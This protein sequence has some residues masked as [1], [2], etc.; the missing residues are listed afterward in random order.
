MRPPRPGL[1]RSA[2]S[3]E[4][5]V[6]RPRG[7]IRATCS[8][9]RVFTPRHWRV[10]SG[11]PTARWVPRTEGGEETHGRTELESGWQ[12]APTSDRPVDGTRPRSRQQSPHLGAGERHGGSDPGVNAVSLRRGCGEP[13]NSCRRGDSS[14]GSA[15]GDGAGSADGTLSRGPH[16]RLATQKRSEPQD[17]QQAATVPAATGR[18]KPSRW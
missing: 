14:R 4:D 8:R 6:T 12:Q 2:G 11:F 15:R 5:R 16:R 7:A 1:A 10:R 13:G 3:A 9:T 17:R 18:S